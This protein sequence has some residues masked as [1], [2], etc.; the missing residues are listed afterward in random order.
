MPAMSLLP[1]L[2]T[3]KADMADFSLCQSASYGTAR[4]IDIAEPIGAVSFTAAPQFT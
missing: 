3:A 2:A 4:E 1:S